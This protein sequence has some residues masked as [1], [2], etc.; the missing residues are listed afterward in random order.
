MVQM[1]HVCV[2]K[3][4]IPD[5]IVATYQKDASFTPKSAITGFQ[6][7]T[8]YNPSTDIQTTNLTEQQLIQMH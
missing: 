3:I 5:V 7:S 8:G 1:T 4:M 6:V 2:K